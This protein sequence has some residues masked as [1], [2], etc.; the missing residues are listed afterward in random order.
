VVETSPGHHHR[1]WLTS[2]PAD[3]QGGADHAAVMERMIQSYGS[4]KGA[5]DI[6]RV[7]R[8]PGFL[9]RKA[10]PHMVRI[11]TAPGHRY[12]RDEILTAFP[13][14]PRKTRPKG[15]TLISLAAWHSPDQDHIT[16]AL[17]HIDADDRQMWLK[18]GM[19]LHDHLGERGRSLWDRWSE[20]SE[21][22]NPLDQEKVWRSFGKRSGIGIGT[23]FHHAIQAGWK[24][25]A[26]S[27]GER[28]TWEAAEFFIEEC[29]PADRWDTFEEWHRLNPLVSRARAEQIFQAV[30]GKLANAG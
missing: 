8:V 18:I 3:D 10:E 17:H 29:A 28:E 9:H 12:S 27:A 4:D 23:L 13:P 20:T 24:P 25:P 2:W 7:L 19:A 14:L 15:A 26:V 30:M 16:D 6:C 21:K 1:Y 11:V 5:K 22:Y